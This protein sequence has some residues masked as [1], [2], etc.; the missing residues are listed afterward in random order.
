MSVGVTSTT[1]EPLL[2]PAGMVTDN[3][4]GLP[5]SAT[6]TCAA[7]TVHPPTGTPTQPKAEPATVKIS[8]PSVSPSENGDTVKSTDAD[9]PQA[10]M[11]ISAS[12][13]PTLS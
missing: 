4:A 6:A 13:S 7:P 10:G 8:T 3:T 12:P 1:A 9:R 2:C 11:T 5:G